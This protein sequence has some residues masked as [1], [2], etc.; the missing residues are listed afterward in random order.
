MARWP[1]QS[2]VGFARTLIILIITILKFETSKRVIMYKHEAQHKLQKKQENSNRTPATAVPRL[3]TGL[4]LPLMSKH[5][6]KQSASSSPQ[7]STCIHCGVMMCVCYNQYHCDLK[8]FKIWRR[9]TVWIVQKIQS[10]A[11]HLV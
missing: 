2:I 9:G 5:F 1:T 7:I 8:S 10:P 11:Q 3:I 4:P 6:D